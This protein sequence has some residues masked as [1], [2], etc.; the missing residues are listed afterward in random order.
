MIGEVF[1]SRF[2]IE[3]FVRTDPELVAGKFVGDHAWRYELSQLLAIRPDLVAMDRAE[4]ITTDALGRFAQNSDVTEATAEEGRAILD[5][6]LLAIEEAVS[7]F[8]LATDQHQ[9]I[10]FDEMEPLAAAVNSEKATWATLK[11]E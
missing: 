2:P 3:H 5:A 9:F 1:S 8:A 10:S 11:A 4:R 7:G 6:S